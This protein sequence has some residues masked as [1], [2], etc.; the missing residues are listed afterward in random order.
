MVRL[1]LTRAPPRGADSV[2]L[3]AFGNPILWGRS[4]PPA[5]RNVVLISID[6][7]RADRL[8]AYGYPLV[9]SPVLDAVAR[10]G[11]LFENA[12]AQASWTTPSHATMLTGTYSCVHGLGINEYDQRPEAEKAADPLLGRPLP[13]GVRPLAEILRDAGY[14]TAAFTEDA[15]VDPGSFQRGFDEFSADR[16][17]GWAA[18]IVEE[19][20][21]SAV[22]WMRVHAEQRF[23]LFVHTYQVHSPYTPPPAYDH[24]ASLRPLPLAP[25]HLPPAPKGEADAARYVAE[26]AYTDASVAALFQALAELD[27]AEQTIVVV[28]SDHGEAFGEQG[29]WGHAWEIKDEQLHV[30][31]IWRA[32]GLIAA[33]RRVSTMVGVVDIAPTVLALLGMEV[34]SWMQGESLASMLAPEAPAPA[35]APPRRVLPAEGY[36]IQGVRGDTW[37]VTRRGAGVGFVTVFETGVETPVAHPA[38]LLLEEPFAL[39]ARECER[40]RAVLGPSLLTLPEAADPGFD[41]ERERKLRALGYLE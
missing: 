18:G 1:A 5:G 29:A 20:V 38:R 16:R 39:V 32:P 11:T 30:P 26:V 12:L 9:V 13:V 19:T 22:D 37:M 35:P 14:G 17:F 27:L 10:E 25:D 4:T 36:A 6:T 40:A 23:F 15:F 3:V 33:G 24:I 2:T 21:R 31:L 34:P 28:T 7:L 41:A 8:G